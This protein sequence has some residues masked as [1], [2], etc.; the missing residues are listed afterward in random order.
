MC[1]LAALLAVACVLCGCGERKGETV[2]VRERAVKRPEPPTRIIVLSRGTLTAS[3][4]AGG[5][6]LVR[7]QKEDGSFHYM[8]DAAT[9][10]SQDDEYN[11][12]RHAG[13]AFSLFDLY[14]H[15]KEARYLTAANRAIDYLKTRFKPA[16]ESNAVYVLDNDGKA[17]L[18]ANG[19]ALLAMARQLELDPNSA[20]RAASMKLANQILTMQEPDGSFISYHRVLGDEPEGSTSLYYPGEAILGLVE[21]YRHTPAE[22]RLLDAAIRAA[23]FLIESQRE[24]PELPPDAW[25]M[26]ALEA[27]H[28]LKPDPKYVQHAIAIAEAMLRDQYTGEETPERY[29][30]DKNIGGFGP[31]EPRST[32]AAARSEGILAGYRMARAANDPRVAT[33]L[34]ALKSSARFQLAHQ[35]TKDDVGWLPAPEQAAGGFRGSLSST[36]VRIDYVQHNISALLG[37]A[38]L[39]D[40]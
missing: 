21:F 6:Y 28:K 23:D 1:K 24:M 3:A 18:G 40:Q 38:Q 22:K 35:F 16:G 34:A 13:T 17:K 14:A 30:G 4:R 31:G 29:M 32:P 9:D 10:R 12:L 19:L 5:D 25:L 20:D 2:P 11:I 36:R 15:T 7:M 33:L 8:Y 27:L 26:Q 37:L 39:W